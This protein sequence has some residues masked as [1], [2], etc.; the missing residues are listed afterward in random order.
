M[1]IEEIYGAVEAILFIS[2]EAVELKLL[3]A[4]VGQDMETAERL[5]KTLMDKLKEEKR[6]VQIIEI[7]GSY[8]MCTNPAYFP[9]ISEMNKIPQRKT[10]TQTQLETLSIVA[11]KQPVTKAEIEKIR[12]VDATHT[13][14]KLMEY[15]LICE[16][17]RDNTPGRPILFATTEKFLTHFGF[18][19]LDQLPGI[20]DDLEKIQ[21]VNTNE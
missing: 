19:S 8:Q 18:S 2:G 12:G 7:N 6:G 5:V 21:E 14:N 13:V 9:Y 16:Y 20:Y 11:Y 10:L 3:A 4:A 15:E 1:K 17:G